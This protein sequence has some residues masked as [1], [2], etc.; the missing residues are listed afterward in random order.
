M[1]ANLRP[2]EEVA[3]ERLSS[4]LPKLSHPVRIGE[5]DQTAFALG[6]MLDFAR[7]SGNDAFGRLSAASAKKFFS[8]IRIARSPT[9]LRAKIFFRPAWAKRT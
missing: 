4:W 5:H 7:V 8:R 9:N 2:L 3:V 1:S 6:L